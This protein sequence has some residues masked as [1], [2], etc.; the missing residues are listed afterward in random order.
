MVPE[1]ASLCG[2]VAGILCGPPSLLLMLGMPSILQHASQRP[3][4]DVRA[5][6]IDSTLQH[7]TGLPGASKLP[8]VQG[9]GLSLS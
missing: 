2:A 6:L 5:S 4:W 8:G 3:Q 1:A 7:C 9:M